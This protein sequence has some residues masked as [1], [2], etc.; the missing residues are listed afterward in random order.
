MDIGNLENADDCPSLHSCLIGYL[1]GATAIPQRL[2]ARFIDCEIERYSEQLQTT[3]GIMQ[4][5]GLPA[6]QRV[7]LTIL[8]K[9]YS[10]RGSGRKESGLSRGLDQQSRALVPKVL[11]ALVSN[12]WLIRSPG[13]GEAI[14]LPVKGRRSAALTALD[15]PGNFH[16]EV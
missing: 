3:A 16:L 4:L 14:Y 7:A 2:S 8:K 9:I 13:R 10:Q 6:E 12:G 1:D 15:K 11:S 5:K